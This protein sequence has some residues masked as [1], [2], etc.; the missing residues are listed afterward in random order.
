MFF[1]LSTI[2]KLQKNLVI[3]KNAIYYNLFYIK[4]QKGV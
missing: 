3:V 2:I 1:L 4:L